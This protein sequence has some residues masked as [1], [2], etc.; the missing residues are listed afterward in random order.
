MCFL[1][2][3]LPVLLVIKL[4]LSFSFISPVRGWWHWLWHSEAQRPRL[5]RLHIW[6]EIQRLCPFKNF[7]P[8]KWNRPSHNNARLHFWVCMWCF[9]PCAGLCTVGGGSMVYWHRWVYLSQNASLHSRLLLIYIHFCVYIHYIS[10]RLSLLP[11]WP[12]AVLAD[13]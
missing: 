13:R 1:F 4:M 10:F 11:W 8:A 9:P 2:Y 5:Y 3:S 12:W 7:L 6:G